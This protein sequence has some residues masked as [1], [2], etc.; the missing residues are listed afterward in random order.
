MAHALV[1]AILSRGTTTGLQARLQR[2]LPPEACFLALAVPMVSRSGLGDIALVYSNL[3]SGQ[4][5]QAALYPQRSSCC[6]EVLQHGQPVRQLL[7][8]GSPL[9]PDVAAA[10]AQ[11]N[12]ALALAVPISRRDAPAGSP[13]LG[14][15]LLG[16]LPTI[17][18]QQAGVA[19]QRWAMRQVLLLAAALALTCEPQLRHLSAN[20]SGLLFKQQ[21][22]T[23]DSGS[24]G[25]ELR[26]DSEDSDGFSS[27]MEGDGSPVQL[28]QHDLVTAEIGWL[29]RF[30][31]EHLERRFLHHHSITMHKV[32][33][34]RTLP[35]CQ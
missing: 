21:R 28:G 35:S 22:A 31:S 18:G 9:P 11:W 2:V 19:T 13:P 25:S 30:K 14:A 20:L 23:S 33:C 1:E 6:G 4:Q 32:R 27:D 7:Q 10:Q 5:V 16:L 29:L 34:C 12:T 8:P 15:L 17:S 24:S 3:L 26:S